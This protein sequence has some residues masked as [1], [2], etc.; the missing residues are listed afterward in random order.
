MSR[1][2][3]GHHGKVSLRG[4]QQQGTAALIVQGI[5]V[6]PRLRRS[7]KSLP[8]KS[9]QSSNINILYEFMYVYTCVYIH[10][11]IY[12]YIYNNSK[13]M[14]KIGSVAIHQNLNFSLCRLQ[15]HGSFRQ[16]TTFGRV[17]QSSV[18]LLAFVPTGN[19]LGKNS[20]L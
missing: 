12:I 15:C 5:H 14:K 20:F 1:L 4:R 7:K 17:Q 2:L 8:K 18:Q 16:V 11:Y 9:E 6:G 19:F 13:M 10:T 3:P